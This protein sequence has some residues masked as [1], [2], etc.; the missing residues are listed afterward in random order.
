[1]SLLR[2]IGAGDIRVANENPPSARSMQHALDNTKG[3]AQSV[4][5]VERLRGDIGIAQ[6]FALGFGT[7][8]GSAWVVLL[9]DWLT[10]AAPGGALL[11]FM[12]GGAVMMIIGRCY[13][14][15]L[16]QLPE[17]GSEFIYAHRVFARAAGFVVGW[18]LIL[19]LV[20]VTIY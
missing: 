18:F 8:I 16:G 15:L 12:A 1:M 11:G 10:I 9:G 2:S 3:R 4:P 19:Y 17:A 20:G 7:I 13:A 5:E 14:E 6:Y